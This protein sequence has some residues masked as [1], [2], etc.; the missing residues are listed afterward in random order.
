MQHPRWREGRLST[1]F[2]AEEFPDGF[3]PLGPKGDTERRM[4]AV[5]AHIDHTLNRRK[6]LI[7]GQLREPDQC[8]S[9]SSVWSPS[10]KARSRSRSKTRR[11]RSRSCSP[12]VIRSRLRSDWKP[13]EPLWRGTVEGVEIA[14]Q[15]RP[16][17]NGHAL[18]QPARPPTR[19][20]TLVAKPS[21]PR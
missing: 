5:A 13:G 16:I 11:T 17:L 4:A 2:I 10:A 8:G 14:V 20:S 15:A 19:A 12:T 7:S 21:S 3:R 1:G 9:S 6:R 18:S